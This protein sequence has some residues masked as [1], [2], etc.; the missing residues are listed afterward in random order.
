[1]VA[2]IEDIKKID[3]KDEDINKFQYIN[4]FKSALYAFLLFIILSNKVAY[5]ILDIIV[6][7]FTNNTEILDSAEN[8]TLLASF[9]NG[10]IVFVII[11]LF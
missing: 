10:L 9:I 7:V 6:N 3:N 5:K 8:P 11:F 2:T 1:M 4:K